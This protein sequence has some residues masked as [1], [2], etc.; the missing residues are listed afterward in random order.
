MIELK[1]ISKVY[2]LKSG[3]IDAVKGVSLTV[4]DG[5]IYGIT[6]RWMVQSR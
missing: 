1:N 3:N 6:E 2:Q 5:E 4:N